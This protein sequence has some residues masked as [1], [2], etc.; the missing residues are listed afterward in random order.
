MA[1][2]EGAAD[3]MNRIGQLATEMGLKIQTVSD[4]GVECTLEKETFVSAYA[5]TLRPFKRAK[6]TIAL[7]DSFEGAEWHVAEEGCRHANRVSKS[8]FV[9]L[10]RNNAVS[11]V[12]DLSVERARKLTAAPLHKYLASLHHAMAAFFKKLNELDAP[13]PGKPALRVIKGGKATL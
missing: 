13:K 9:C 4:Y 2:M 12:V 11:A 5:F 6:L 7:T 8:V 3:L 10:G 1:T